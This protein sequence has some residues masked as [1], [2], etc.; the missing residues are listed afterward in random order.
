MHARYSSGMMTGA[1]G[2][3]QTV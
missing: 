2:D 1:Q 3:W